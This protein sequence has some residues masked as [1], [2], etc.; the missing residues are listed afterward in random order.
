MKALITE[1]KHR[2]DLVHHRIAAIT[3]EQ[4]LLA[5]EEEHLKKL[6]E[7][8]EKQYYDTIVEERKITE[9]VI[10]NAPEIKF[11]VQDKKKDQLP[12]G[13]ILNAV[14]IFIKTCP[15]NHFSYNNL[16]KH[17]NEYV[18]KKVSNGSIGP[19]LKKMIKQGLINKADYGKYTINK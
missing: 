19:A 2:L 15:E 17:I 5:S 12:R 14:E 13:T 3:A 1:L 16:V 10:P 9:A 18:G 6:L 7:Q 11:I 4:T 8:Y